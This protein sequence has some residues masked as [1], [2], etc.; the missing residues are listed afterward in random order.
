MTATLPTP[1]FTNIDP[2]VLWRKA[3]DDREQGRS[4]T[5]DEFCE[6][7]RISRAMF[8]KMDAEGFAPATYNIGTRRL[9]S[10]EADAAWLRAREAENQNTAA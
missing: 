10:A 1:I 8:Y 5:V 3:M 4:F 6:R 2:S 9:I 7:H